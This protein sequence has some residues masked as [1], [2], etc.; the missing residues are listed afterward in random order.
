MSKLVVLG[1]T[2][3]LMVVAQALAWALNET[4]EHIYLFLILGG[5]IAILF[6][7]LPK[8]EGFWLPLEEDK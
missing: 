4:I 6:E 1:T 3:L 5:V 8:D 7:V 2:I